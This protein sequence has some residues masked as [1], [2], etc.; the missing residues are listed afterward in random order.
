MMMMMR[1]VHDSVS[2]VIRVDLLQRGVH[3]FGQWW[4][5]L[6]FHHGKLQRRRAASA[7]HDGLAVRYQ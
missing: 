1:V 2:R 7:E 3:D 6:Q 5:L 4:W